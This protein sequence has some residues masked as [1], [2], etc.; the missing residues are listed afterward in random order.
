MRMVLA[1]QVLFHISHVGTINVYPWGEKEHIQAPKH[2][3]TTDP[4]LPSRIHLKVPHHWHREDENENISEKRQSTVHR[5]GNSL[6]FARAAFD[7]AIIVI[8]DW[9]A[10]GQIDDPG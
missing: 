6:V 2:K 4:N 8:C 3:D 9:D 5:P 7:G 10:D 1:M